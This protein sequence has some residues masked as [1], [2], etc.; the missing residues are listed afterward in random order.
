MPIGVVKWF[1]IH[2]RFG[3]I[4][5]NKG[6]EDVFVH[7]SALSDIRKHSLPLR[8]GWGVEYDLRET[9]NGLQAANV[10]RRPDM[11]LP[12]PKWPRADE[13]AS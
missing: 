6:G 4:L 12:P 3:F 11:D 1:D 9:Q 10:R 7:L 5:P 13:A 8:E 2:K